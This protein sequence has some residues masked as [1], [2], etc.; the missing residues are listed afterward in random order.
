MN[1]KEHI[2]LSEGFSKKL[3]RD[4]SER[5]GFEN[6]PGK[7]TIGW[8][9]N[10]DDKGLPIDILEILLNREIVAATDDLINNFPWVS[11]L[12][13]VRRDV[14]IEMMYNL[15][16]KTFSAFKGTLSAVEKGD[17]KLAALHM[18]DSLWA[19]QVGVRANRLAKKME[20]GNE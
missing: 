10:I 5:I 15:G 20:F 19:K 11:E 8:G 18:L 9:Y 17:Y 14:L 3:Y 4:T 6:K 13:S 16:L 2:K 7:L 12:D 1:L